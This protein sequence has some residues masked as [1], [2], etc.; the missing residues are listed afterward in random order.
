MARKPSQTRAKVTVEAII[1]AGFLSIAEHGLSGTTTRHIAEIAGVS[2]GSLYEYFDNKE[3]IFKAM[4]QYFVDEV[5]VMIVELRPIIVQTDLESVIEM[6]FYQLS[7]LLKKN[8]NRYLN[9]LR[10][11]GEL[12]YDD[13]VQQI[14]SALVETV[15]KYIVHNPQYMRLNDIT[16][17]AYV[18]INSGIFNVIR[19]LIMPNPNISFDNMVKGLTRMILSYVEAEMNPPQ[20]S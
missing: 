10:Y 2:V 20:Q 17:L 1:E 9:G 3:A 15:L 14:E 16:T 5:L 18:C 12:K 8:N 4:S 6:I 11:A 7:D 13:H 19:H